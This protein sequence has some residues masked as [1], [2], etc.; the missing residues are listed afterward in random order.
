MSAVLDRTRDQRLDALE[1]ANRTRVIRSHL[2]HDLKTGQVEAWPIID[3]PGDELLTMHLYDLLLAVPRYGPHKATRLMVGVGVARGKT[4][5]GLTD[6][7][8]AMLVDALKE[9]R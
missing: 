2:K 5:G 8:R 7:Q 4:L 1:K 9:Q 6:R 3:D